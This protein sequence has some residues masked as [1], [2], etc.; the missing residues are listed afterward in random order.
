ML[1][2]SAVDHTDLRL[3]DTLSPESLHA[4]IEGDLDIVWH[5][6][7]YPAS[8]AASVLPRITFACNTAHH[9]FAAGFQSLGTSID[10]T[11]GSPANCARYFATVRAITTLIRD[12]LFARLPSPLDRLRVLLDEYSPSGA[13]LARG[14]AP[15]HEAML[16]GTIRRWPPGGHTSPHI[17]RCQNGMLEHF[18]LTRRIG[19]DVYLQVPELDGGGELEFWQR[20]DEAIYLRGK[21]QDHGLDRELLGLAKA[22]LL[23]EQ[24]DLIM[25]D[26]SIVHAVAPVRSGARVTASL[27][28]GCRT[29]SHPLALFA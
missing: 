19:I 16:P 28:A 22:A 29:A 2:G 13:S 21:R 25:F 5:K 4:M 20:M 24:G 7:F 1:S 15:Q 3:A 27:F 10:D 11:A 18:E 6:R 8:I 17:D 14:P 23:P 9:T 12:D 26:T